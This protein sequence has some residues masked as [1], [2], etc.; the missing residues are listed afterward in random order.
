MGAIKGILQKHPSILLFEDCSHAR[1]AR[2][3][4]KAVGTFG[5][6][7]VWSLQGQKIVSGG[8]GGIALTRHAK[9]HYRMLCWGHYNK[10]CKAEIPQ[11]HKL[12]LYALTGAGVKN[13]AHPLA[14]SVALT[15]LRKL[16][17][18]LSNKATF[19][20]KMIGALKTIPFLDVPDLEDHSYNHVCPAWY[21][22]VVRFKQNKAPFGL[23]R[24]TFVQSLIE[25]GLRDVDIPRSTGLLH[26]EPLYTRPSVVL[27]H[28][29][30]TDVNMADG[31]SLEFPTAQKF[32]DEAIKFFVY[33]DLA[34]GVRVDHFVRTITELGLCSYPLPTTCI[35]EVSRSHSPT[36]Q[37]SQSDRIPSNVD[38]VQMETILNGT[39]THF[40]ALS[41]SSAN[42]NFF[43]KVVVGAAVLG[44]TVNGSES[45]KLLPRLQLLLLKRAEHEPYY[46]N[47][48]ELPSGKVSTN[49]KSLLDAFLRELYEESGL[50]GTRVLGRLPNM[51]YET[52]KMVHGQKVTRRAV[53]LNFVVEIE[54]VKADVKVNVNEH[55][56]G[57][58]WEAEQLKM[59][60]ITDGMR[61]IVT[62]AFR[63]RRRMRSYSSFERHIT[64]VFLVS[65]Y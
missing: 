34:D 47:V 50:K 17:D 41:A 5:D 14:I 46:P 33:A 32:Y 31:G 62:E 30:P 29:Y 44:F 28:I 13:R 52:S 20:V 24:E 56:E 16:N 12:R 51:V 40:H 25:R 59:L 64:K 45:P 18:V 6:G 21:A 7:A 9:F 42:G 26:R 22:L 58:W 65:L 19:A 37:S 38:S 23:S 43:D 63:W 49:D 54:D 4:G 60:D 57:G 11:D 1:G 3:M 10:R 35:S 55:S 8:E 39:L 53:Q 2:V 48:F 36:Q 15:Q 61:E 27:P